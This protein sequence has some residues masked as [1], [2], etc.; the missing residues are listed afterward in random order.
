MPNYLPLSRHSTTIFRNLAAEV[1]RP[2]F[3]ELGGEGVNVLS[4]AD[5]GGDGE[6]CPRESPL[7]SLFL[8]VSVRLGTMLW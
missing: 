8:L 2:V 5:E 4:L 1:G 3:A 7:A 6:N